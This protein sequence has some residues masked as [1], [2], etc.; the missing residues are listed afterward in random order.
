MAIQVGKRY[1][2]ESCS[3]EVLVTKPSDTILS[4]WGEAMPMLEP[5]KI[6]SAD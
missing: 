1:R 2:C 5:K 3:T 6:G 4:C